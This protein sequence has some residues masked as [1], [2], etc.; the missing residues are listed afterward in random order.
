MR[1]EVVPDRSSTSGTPPPCLLLQQ[2]DVGSGEETDAAAALSLP[3]ALVDH[4]YVGDDFVRVE[5]DL[6]VGFC[7]AQTKRR[8]GLASEM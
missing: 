1:L 4:L 3:P 2:L 7:A 8:R 5:G 6:V